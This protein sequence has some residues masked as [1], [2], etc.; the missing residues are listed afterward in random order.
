VTWRWC[1]S[2]RR[3]GALTSASEGWPA[4]DLVA[5][6]SGGLLSWSGKPMGMPVTTSG[7]LAR[8]EF[9]GWGIRVR[10]KGFLRRLLPTFEA[11]FEES[12]LMAPKSGLSNCTKSMNCRGKNLSAPPCR[13]SH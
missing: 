6:F 11:R 10:G 12:A 9:Y 4:D 13:R 1:G 3:R 5:V 2:F 7:G 8:L